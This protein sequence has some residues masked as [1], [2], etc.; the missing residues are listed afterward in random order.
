[1]T[2]VVSPLVALMQDQVNMKINRHSRNNINN[3]IL[4]LLII[5]GIIKHNDIIIFH[6]MKSWDGKNL[7]MKLI[8]DF[9]IKCE[10]CFYEKFLLV[11]LTFTSIR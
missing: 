1:M 3:F 4:I 11:G 10:I 8:V 9:F 7:I 2:L 6:S 5:N